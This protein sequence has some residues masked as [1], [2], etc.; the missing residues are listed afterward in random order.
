MDKPYPA[1]PPVK[2][3]EELHTASTQNQQ[4]HPRP[5][6][7]LAVVIASLFLIA[8]AAICAWL[9]M[10][11]PVTAVVSQQPA[12]DGS[13]KVTS[14]NFVPPDGMPAAYARRDQ[15]ILDTQTS[16]YFYSGSSCGLITNVG[17]LAGSTDIQQAAL[18]AVK[19]AQAKD[20]AVT[21]TSKA[22]NMKLKDSD[23]QHE[24]SF[25]GVQLDQNISMP[26]L[27]FN[28]QRTV[29]AYKQFGSNTASISMVCPK[30][31]W[32]SKQP[33]LQNLASGFKVKTQK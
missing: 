6:L 22:P 29:V 10:K 33:E 13:E 7:A 4:V 23:G 19:A 21:A 20:I 1:V 11:S 16:Y 2:L 8:S 26:G 28:Q 25:S 17:P 5:T 31:T 3:M 27:A 15:N 18:A 30:D 32:A 14:L 24:Y 9:I 12:S